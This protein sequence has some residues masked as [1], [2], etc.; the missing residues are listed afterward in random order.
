MIHYLNCP[1]VVKQKPHLWCHLGD[2]TRYAAANLGVSAVAVFPIRSQIN[3]D[4]E[5]SFVSGEGAC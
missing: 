5:L 1:N 2:E 3:F 4:C